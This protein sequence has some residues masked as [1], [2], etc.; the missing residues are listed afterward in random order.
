MDTEP[1][2]DP[3]PHCYGLG[4]GP[5]IVANEMVALGSPPES[6][7]YVR[8]GGTGSIPARAGEPHART[9]PSVSC[10][11]LAQKADLFTTF[12]AA[13]LRAES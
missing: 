6:V 12:S 4:T 10:L 9:V 8:S 7:E 13:R 3:S 11:S 1:A 5:Q 2:K